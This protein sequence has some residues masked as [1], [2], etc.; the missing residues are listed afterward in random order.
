M[1]IVNPPEEIEKTRHTTSDILLC[2]L[3]LPS[4]HFY[5]WTPKKNNS[6]GFSHMSRCSR[7]WHGLQCPVWSELVFSIFS[8]VFGVGLPF[9]QFSTN[10]KDQ[11]NF[12]NS[13][14][15]L[16]THCK[17]LRFRLH[18][19]PFRLRF[20]NSDCV[21]RLEFSILNVIFN[22][23]LKL[24]LRNKFF[25]SQTQFGL[26]FLKKNYSRNKKISLRAN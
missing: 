10:R 23:R 25:P 5:R 14:T 2:I 4:G 11:L 12:F 21:F 8:T 16:K 19:N 18:F 9:F 1:G 20:F 15:S 7:D 17:W 3:Y 26:T 13:Q 6:Q 24:S 22:Y